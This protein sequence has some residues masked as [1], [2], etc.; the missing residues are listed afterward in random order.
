MPI[1]NSLVGL[2]ILYKVQLIKYMAV[3]TRI[4]VNITCT[5]ASAFNSSLKVLVPA[6]SSSSPALRHLQTFKFSKSLL[7]YTFYLSLYW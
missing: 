2:E 5:R 6:L 3:S 7:L 1:T 4:Q